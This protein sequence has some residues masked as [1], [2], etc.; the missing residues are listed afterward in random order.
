MCDR[1]REGPRG[2]SDNNLIIACCLV[3]RRLACST[4][5]P[6]SAEINHG[7][8]RAVVWPHPITMLSHSL[9][10]HTSSLD[11]PPPPNRITPP[12]SCVCFRPTLFCGTGDA[13]L[14]VEHVHDAPQQK[15]SFDCGMYTVLMA[16][17]LASKRAMTTLPATAA[18]AQ[19]EVTASSREGM[20][21]SPRLCKNNGARQAEESV[22]VP[23]GD[24]VGGADSSGR[25]D[26][27]E[28]T[29]VAAEGGRFDGVASAGGMVM[30]SP[31]F[32]ANARILARERLARCIRSQG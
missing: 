19:S 29:M 32:V 6:F 3:C 28:G 14:L 4:F 27:R 26:S 20:V 22:L 9:P 17:G 10:T 8:C 13:P 21:V 1:E 12:P 7:L 23:A 24:L 5:F 31:E 16:E 25:G 15:N 11:C 30:I 18:M 2:G